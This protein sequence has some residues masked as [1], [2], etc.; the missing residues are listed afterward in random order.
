VS[1]PT[2]E[3]GPEQD[4]APAR[5]SAWWAR[6]GS[7]AVIAVGLAVITVAVAVWALLRPPAAPAPTPATSQQVADAKARACA[8]FT[9]VRR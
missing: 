6:P 5:G 1:E 4:S 7:V 8:A 3:V 2:G 9:T